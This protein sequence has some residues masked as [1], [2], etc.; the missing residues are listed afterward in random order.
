MSELL[1]TLPHASSVVPLEILAEMLGPR[2][3]DDAARA[4][5]RERLRRDGDPFTD[6]LFRLPG[7]R[8]VSATVSRFVVDLNR[9]PHDRSDNGVVKVTDFAGLPLYPP[10]GAPDAAAVEGR[11]RRFHAPFHAQIDREVARSRPRLIVDGHSMSAE[12]PSLGPDHGRPRPAASLITGGGPDGEPIDRPVS[13]APYLA[14]QLAAELATSLGRRLPLGRDGHPSGVRI[15]DPFPVGH[16]QD[17]CGGDPGGLGVPTVGIEIHRGLF[18]DKE[19]RA[20]PDRVA[21]IRAAV[22]EAVTALLPH[23]G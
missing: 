8:F 21:A 16:V 11:I 2:V 14:R 5:L 17:R 20:R 6:D 23:L 10:G 19:V 7:A 3:D 13:L 9:A 1:V 4:D 22:A 18:E 15:N 12:G